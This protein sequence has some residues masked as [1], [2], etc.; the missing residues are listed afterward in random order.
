[1]RWTWNTSYQQLFD[2][3]K[4]I[5][6]ADVCMKFYDDSKPLYLETDA[7]GVGLGAALL[8]LHNNTVCQK[9]IAPD[10]IT[11]CPIAFASKSLT[12]VEWRY[13]NTKCEV[14]GIL[15]GLEKFHHYHFGRE[16]LIITD[17]KPLVA[18]FKKDVATLLQHTQHILVKF[19]NIG[20]R[21][22]TNLALRFSLHTGYQGTTM[23]RAR[24]S[25]QR[26]WT[27]GWTPYKTQ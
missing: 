22:Y 7:S 18:M 12:S 27:H 6:K 3:A 4:S 11:L 16:V 8:Q 15:H 9:G 2:K 23:W 5:I 13:S 26:T 19:I 14:L 1:M 24:T 21:L 25:L 17:H 10:N 20:S